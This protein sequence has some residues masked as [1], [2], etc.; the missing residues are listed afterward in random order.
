MLIQYLLYWAIG[1]TI[2]LELVSI[3]HVVR[4]EFDEAGQFFIGLG[5]VMALMFIFMYYAIEW[6]KTNSPTEFSPDLY[7]ATTLFLGITSLI[8]IL[9]IIKRALYGLLQRFF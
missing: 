1:L 7:I 6:Y 8:V 5:Q 9:Y 3:Y 2:V 4:G